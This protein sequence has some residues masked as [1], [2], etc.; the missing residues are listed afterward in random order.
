MISRRPSPLPA[1]TPQSWFRQHRQASRSR[2][3]YYDAGFDATWELDLFGRV[4]RGVE[5]RRAE[6]QGAEASLRDAQVSVIAEVARTYFELR[7][8]QTQLA[9]AERNVST[10]ATP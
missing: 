2:R 9:V 10:R 5:A 1:G 4:R 7:G 3:R 6:L 8:Q